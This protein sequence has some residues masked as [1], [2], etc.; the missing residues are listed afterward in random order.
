MTHDV[1]GGETEEEGERKEG[2]RE[3]TKD[4]RYSVSLFLFRLLHR[5]PLVTPIL[6]GRAQRAAP[7]VQVL[8]SPLSIKYPAS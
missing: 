6:S 4:K 7:T 3:E 1:D 5:L 8:A 2:G